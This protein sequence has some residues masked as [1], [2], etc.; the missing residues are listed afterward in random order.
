[1]DVPQ[2][3]LM[4]N[5]V[6]K[7]LMDMAKQEAE[8]NYQCEVAAVVPHSDDLMTLASSGVFSSKYPDHP[9]TKIYRQLANRILAG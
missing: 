6:P 9:V 2:M 3:L 4:I 8:K 5:K 1:L 7:Q